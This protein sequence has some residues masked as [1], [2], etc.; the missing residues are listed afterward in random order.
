MNWVSSYV[1]LP[2]KERGLTRDGLH[3]WG[4][5]RL[6][7]AEQR[8]IELPS[9]G[10]QSAADLVAAARFFRRDSRR[11]PW[12]KVDTPREFDVAL[13]SA[14]SEEPRPRVMEG[15]CGVMI[16]ATTVLHVWSATHAVQMRLSHYLI[17]HR[18]LGFYR[19]KAQA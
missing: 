15:H 9:Y 3:C 19:H 7:L 2:F 4:L 10:E 12:A 8:G 11:D 6:V 14:M 13:M 17:R 5:V 16:D 1:G 18:V